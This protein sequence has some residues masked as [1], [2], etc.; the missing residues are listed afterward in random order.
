[1][2]ELG[3][4]VDSSMPSDH[5]VLGQVLA[6]PSVVESELQLMRPVKQGDLAYLL[7]CQLVEQLSR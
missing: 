1:M 4:S 5:Q 6:G 7:T 2:V 3:G